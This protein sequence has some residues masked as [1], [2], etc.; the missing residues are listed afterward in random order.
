MAAPDQGLFLPED[1]QEHWEFI[2]AESR[3]INQ[4]PY[5]DGIAVVM[6]SDSILMDDTFAGITALEAKAVSV[7]DV[8]D[9][10]YSKLRTPEELS[11]MR[12]LLPKIKFWARP[13]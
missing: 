9:R 4:A 12:F 2:E 7:F 8:R 1:Q 13:R 11:F 10:T 6:D 3:Q 5:E